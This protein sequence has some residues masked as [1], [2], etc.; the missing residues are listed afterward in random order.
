MFS[1]RVILVN[2]LLCADTCFVEPTLQILIPVSI[3]IAEG[4]E[5]TFPQLQLS[6]FRGSRRDAEQ[7]NAGLGGGPESFEALCIQQT[8]TPAESEH[9]RLSLGDLVAELVAFRIMGFLGRCEL[10]HIEI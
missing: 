5:V 1:S 7:A 2:F 3:R 6:P 9:I 4:I 10:H 8:V